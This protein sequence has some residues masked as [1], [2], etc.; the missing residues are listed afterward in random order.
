[1]IDI[2]LACPYSHK[3]E[4]IREWRFRQASLAAGELIRKG[5]VVFSPVTHGHPIA[6]ECDLPLDWEYWKKVSEVYIRLSKRM[7]ILTLSGWEKSVGIKGEIE[8][9][10]NLG[11]DIYYWKDFNSSWEMTWE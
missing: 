9:A 8:I 4:K 10:G 6:G 5:L 1:M 11:K 3:D 2:Y 7:V